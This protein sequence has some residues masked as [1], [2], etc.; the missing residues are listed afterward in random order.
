MFFKGES[1][2]GS[3]SSYLQQLELIAFFAGFPMLY[4]AA[5]VISGSSLSRNKYGTKLVSFLPYSY[6]LVATLYFGLQIRTQYDYYSPG[7]TSGQFHLPLTVI[8]GLLANLFWIPALAKK[9]VLSLLH[10]SIFFFPVVKDIFL[11]I[12]TNE[13]DRNIVSNDMKLYTLSLIIN[14]AALAVVFLVSFLY[15]WFSRNKE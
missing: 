4:A 7:I 2:D 9:P 13:V 14:I 10:S 12:T 3:F 1:I 5:S 15:R 6:A 11:Q 8:W